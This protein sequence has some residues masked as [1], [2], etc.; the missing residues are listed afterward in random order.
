M[1]TKTTRKMLLSGADYQRLLDAKAFSR[2][3]DYSV[4]SLRGGR[5]YQLTSPS[6]V[7]WQRVDTLFPPQTTKLGA[8]ASELLKVSADL[9]AG[10]D[11][12]DAFDAPSEC[13]ALVANGYERE[14]LRVAQH[15]GFRTVTAAIDAI[16]A[17]TTP[18]VAYFLGLSELAAAEHN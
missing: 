17:R 3:A 5:T 8:L 4:G 9:H 10:Y 16:A 7:L 2:I 11:D 14:A 1:T 15:Y 6:R 18:R 12:V 13:Y